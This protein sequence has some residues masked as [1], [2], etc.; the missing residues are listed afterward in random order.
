MITVR[1]RHREKFR[2]HEKLI[3]EGTYPQVPARGDFI[4]IDGWW[5][6]VVARHWSTLTGVV[7]VFVAVTSERSHPIEDH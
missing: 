7:E 3:H 6:Q 2:H 1:F 4:N 5:Y